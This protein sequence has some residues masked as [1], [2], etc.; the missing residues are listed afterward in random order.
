MDLDLINNYEI[1][2][3]GTG[4]AGVVIAKSLLERGH[5]VLLIELG[6][7]YNKESNLSS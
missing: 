2:I 4:P 5:K 6:G 3:V 7:D 1:C